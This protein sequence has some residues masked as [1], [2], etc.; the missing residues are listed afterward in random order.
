MVSP[1]SARQSTSLALTWSSSQ[2]APISSHGPP[3][4]ARYLLLTF[5]HFPQLLI[6]LA[7]CLRTQ[8]PCFLSSGAFQALVFSMTIVPKD[9]R[10]IN[11]SGAGSKLTDYV[12]FPE[13]LCRLT[14]KDVFLDNGTGD[15]YGYSYEHD[16]WVVRGNVGIMLRRSAETCTT[17]GR[18]IIKSPVS[19]S[20]SK[21]GRGVEITC[22]VRNTAVQHFLFSKL[23]R[24]FLVPAKS[25]WE[26]LPITTGRPLRILGE[27][28][29]GPLIVT[30]DD[31]CI[32][33]CQF[34]LSPRYPAT[35]DLLR[36]FIRHKSKLI[37]VAIPTPIEVKMEPQLD[38]PPSRLPNRRIKLNVYGTS[39]RSSSIS[40]EISKTENSPP[41]PSLTR[42]NTT[43][44]VLVPNIQIPNF[45]NIP[46]NRRTSGCL[47]YTSPSPRDRQK[48]RMP[49]SA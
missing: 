13:Q 38:L 2:A 23:S 30:T 1:P 21:G 31:E 28:V 47:L 32:V 27:S 48:S 19:R 5:S 16:D 33:A 42:V 22:C 26:M 10:V 18:F 40:S 34:E 49:S 17:L 14:G 25:D 8:K 43:R 15:I 37:R 12:R 6:L 29:K 9:I 46:I 44:K 45:A 3:S 41:A 4:T 24:D 11:G 35:V 20:L 36:N 7:T 39:R